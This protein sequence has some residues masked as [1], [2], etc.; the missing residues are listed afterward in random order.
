MTDKLRA[1]INEL[2]VIAQLRRVAALLN[3]DQETYMPVNGSS[4]RSEQLSLILSL[5]HIRFIGSEFEKSL[6]QLVDLES[7]KLTVDELDERQG[8]MVQ[9]VWRDWHRAKKNPH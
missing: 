2:L 6:S 1:F 5:A 8:K 9:T 7:G 3:W 4:A